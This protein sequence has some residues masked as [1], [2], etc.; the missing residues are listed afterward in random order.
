MAEELD[1]DYEQLLEELF[2]MAVESARKLKMKAPSKERMKQAFKDPDW[3]PKDKSEWDKHVEVKNED[4]KRVGFVDTE[5]PMV[6]NLKDLSPEGLHSDERDATRRGGGEMINV[7]GDHWVLAETVAE[8]NKLRG[9][10]LTDRETAHDWLQ[11][12][13]WSVVTSE[14]E[15][16]DVDPGKASFIDG[17]DVVVPETVPEAVVHNA[18]VETSPTTNTR[19]AG[20]ANVNGADVSGWDEIEADVESYGAAPNDLPPDTGP[21]RKASPSVQAEPARPQASPS[22]D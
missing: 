20:A 21:Q 15:I 18:R 10:T 6:T 19:V 7:G 14:T 17:A 9:G 5:D 2:V 3:A 11:E 22:M 13:G 1:H 8:K 12:H 4:G 16:D